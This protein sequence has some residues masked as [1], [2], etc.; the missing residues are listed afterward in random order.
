M[1]KNKIAF[2]SINTSISTYSSQKIQ[3]LLVRK[4]LKVLQLKLN[5]LAC[6]N[7]ILCV[8]FMSVCAGYKT[9]EWLA[10]DDSENLALMTSPF[11]SVWL[12]CSGWLTDAWGWLLDLG[13]WFDG[14]WL[15]APW[16]LISDWFHQPQSQAEAP[17]VDES[18]EPAFEVDFTPVVAFISWPFQR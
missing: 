2:Q 7:L 16:V 18:S 6:L 12:A 13:G 17:L 14:S 11:V 15:W 9:L 10:E 4:L 8:V 1:F 5:I 3:N